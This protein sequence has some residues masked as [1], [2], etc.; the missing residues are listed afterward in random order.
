MTHPR[1]SALLCAALLGACSAEERPVPPLE[2][3]VKGFGITV[4][5]LP[6]FRIYD[7]SGALVLHEFGF[8]AQAFGTALERALQTP[9]PIAGAPALAE[10]LKAFS[11]RSG[12]GD[13]TEFE[14]H[15]DTDF[16]FVEY[17]AEWCAPCKQQL[18]YVQRFLQTQPPERIAWVKVESH[19]PTDLRAVRAR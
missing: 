5:R 14:L 10:T 15:A 19:S 18:A 4:T 2:S 16:V 9:R 12:C 1:R 6:E 3:A 8:E 7:R 11:A 13:V 17:W